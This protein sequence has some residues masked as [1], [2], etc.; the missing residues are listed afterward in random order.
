MPDYS[1]QSKMDIVKSLVDTAE[2]GSSVH[3]QQKMAILVKCTEDLE[4]SLEAFQKSVD[5]H[6][7]SND[8]LGKRIYFLI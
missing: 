3:E 8:A 1:G 5:R 2:P 6:A 7:D 4:K